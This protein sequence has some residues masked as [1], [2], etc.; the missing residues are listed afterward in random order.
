MLPDCIAYDDGADRRRQAGVFTGCGPRGRPS[1]WRSDPA[2]FA[3]P[4]AVHR[5]RFVQI[6]HLCGTAGQ[7]PARDPDRVHRGAGSAG[8]PGHAVAPPLRP[9]ARATGRGPDHRGSGRLTAVFDALPATGVPADQV[10]GELTAL[11][12]SDLPTHGG[13][14]FAYV[15]DSAVPGLDDLAVAAYALSAHVN[16]L[17][18]TAFPSLLAM[19]NALVGPRPELLGGGP[20]HAGARCG[21]QRHQ[22]RH[23]VADP[24]G[25]DGPRLATGHRAP[26]PGDRR[27]RAHAAFA[28]AAHYLG[29]ELDSCRCGADAPCRPGGDGRGH[30]RRHRAGRVFGAVVRAR[31]HRPGRRDRGRGGGTRACAATWTRASAAGCCPTCAGS[32]QACRRSTSPCPGS[33]DLGRPAQVRV[34]AEGR[35]G[36]AAPRRGA[37]RSRSTS[38]TP[39]GPATRWSTR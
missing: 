1:G 23:R 6:G 31:C 14:L 35:L 3:D 19:E 37:A 10:L 27:R 30:H 24:G 2:I 32:V 21:R 7:R 13:R 25:E 33:L 22:R 17:D 26:A 16:G 29:V 38:P 36:A 12:R 39:T 9:H 11:R 8:R 5:V 20:W 15:Y 18:P 4:A 34:R 28:K